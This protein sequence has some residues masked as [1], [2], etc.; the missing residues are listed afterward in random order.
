MPK[1]AEREIIIIPEGEI[2]KQSLV[3]MIARHITGGDYAGYLARISQAQS[4][5]KAS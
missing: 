1:A 2:D 4:E 5:A 3:E